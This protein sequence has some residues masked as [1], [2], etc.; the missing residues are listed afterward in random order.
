MKKE[1]K[2]VEATNTTTSAGH[3]QFKKGIL[4]NYNNFHSVNL[5]YSTQFDLKF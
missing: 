2:D 5:N 1:M 4:V 3:L